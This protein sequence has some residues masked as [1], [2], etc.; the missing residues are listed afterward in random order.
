MQAIERAWELQL[1]GSLFPYPSY[2]NRVFGLREETGTEYVAKFYRPGR[3]SQKAISEE[4]DFL[5]DCAV[6]EIPVVQP[7]VTPDGGTLGELELAEDEQNSSYT[8]TLFPKRAGRVFDAEEDSDWLRLGRLLGRLHAVGRKRPAIHRTVC[9]P[10]ET[11]ARYVRELISTRLVHPDI[12]DDYVAICDQA[13]RWITPQFAGV[14]LQRVH[15]DCH[16]GNILVHPDKGLLLIDF[17]D[18]MMGPVVQDLWLL[19]PG[20]HHDSGRE[21]G[22][23]LEGYENFQPFPLATLRLIEP[24]RFMRMIHYEVWCARQRHDVSFTAHFPGWGSR[25]WWSKE[26]EDLRQQLDRLNEGT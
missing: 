10:A 9:T 2:V 18:M 26:V 5:S 13:L 23:L 11:T 15:G 1:D 16:R 17:D 12:E 14:E 20:S 22:L 8:F 3:W 21:I 6:A 4:H 24:L 25:A 19:L 7:L